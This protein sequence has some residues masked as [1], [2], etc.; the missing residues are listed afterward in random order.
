MMLRMC[1]GAG[2]WTKI[3]PCVFWIKWLHRLKIQLSTSGI[4]YM[5]AAANK[6]SISLKASR[7]S[8][9]F[10]FL[11]ALMN[12]LMMLMYSRYCNHHFAVLDALESSDLNLSTTFVRR[13]RRYR[14]SL[15][16]SNPNFFGPNLGIFFQV[17]KCQINLL[18]LVQ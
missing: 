1:A 8:W 18:G 10:P 7:C 2:S 14:Y 4:I 6:F 9:Q 16:H 17:K 11:P 5:T 15:H 3:K 13:Y 12:I